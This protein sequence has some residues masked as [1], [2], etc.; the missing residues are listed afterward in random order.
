[1]HK[2]REDGSSYTYRSK[3][4]AEKAGIA[5]GLEGSHS[6]KT[7]TGETVYMPGRNHK[8]FMESQEKKPDGRKVKTKYQQ[9]RD[10]MYRKRLKDMS[11]KKYSETKADHP[12]SAHKKDKKKG[13]YMDGVQSDTGTIGRAFDEVL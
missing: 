5:L 12:S 11:Y 7:E 4:E 8:E 6:H 3:T 1:M 9:A 2:L 10:E 13:P